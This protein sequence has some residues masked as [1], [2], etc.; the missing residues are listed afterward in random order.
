MNLTRRRITLLLSPPPETVRSIQRC[1]ADFLA[2]RQGD[3]NLLNDIRIKEAAMI[4]LL[5]LQAD[6]NLT[7][8]NSRAVSPAPDESAQAPANPTYVSNLGLHEAG[9]QPFDPTLQTLFDLFWTPQALSG[10]LYDTG[11]F[12]LSGPRE[13]HGDLPWGDINELLGAMG[14]GPSGDEGQPLLGSRI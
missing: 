5:Q 8:S 1:L 4:E 14:G 13:E 2:R 11:A 12:G 9:Q 6:R 3:A 10:N 7:R